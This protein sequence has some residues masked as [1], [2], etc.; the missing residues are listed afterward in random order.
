MRI[1]NHHTGYFKNEIIINTKLFKLYYYA[2]GRAIVCV[3]IVS[4]EDSFVV[5]SSMLYKYEI[6]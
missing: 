4:L 5:C 6:K 2:G 3:K 1:E